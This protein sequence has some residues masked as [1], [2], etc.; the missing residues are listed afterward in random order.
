[1]EEQLKWQ[2]YLKLLATCYIIIDL[3]LIVIG[4]LIAANA[5][6]PTFAYGLFDVTPEMFGGLDAQTSMTLLGGVLIAGYVLNLVVSL[7]VYRGAKDPSKLKPGL[8]LSFIFAAA[9]LVNLAGTCL[10]GNPI[11]TI[12]GQSILAC[13]QAY[14]CYHVFQLSK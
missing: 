7:L 1:M 8:V 3:T 2:R 5:V 9:C 11:G 10:A 12:L 4:G 6:D 13:V 14:G